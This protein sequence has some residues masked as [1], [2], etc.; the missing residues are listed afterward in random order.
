MG[1]TNGGD[2]DGL[3]VAYLAQIQSEIIRGINERLEF[4][5][6]STINFA[7]NGGS[8][9]YP[10]AAELAGLPI[11]GSAVR[12]N[13][14]LIRSTIRAASWWGWSAGGFATPGFDGY[15]KRTVTG[16]IGGTAKVY[17]LFSSGSYDYWD[18]ILADIGYTATDWLVGDHALDANFW[19]GA[20]KILDRCVVA[21]L[22]PDSDCFTGSNQRYKTNAVAQPTEA[23]AWSGITTATPPYTPF[24]TM[25]Y[26]E[27][28]L[29]NYR[30]TVAALDMD[31]DCETGKWADVTATQIGSLHSTWSDGL[32]A[33]M[34]DSVWDDDIDLGDL[35]VFTS[36][37]GIYNHIVSS[38]TLTLGGTTSLSVSMANDTGD[39]PFTITDSGGWL[40]VFFSTYNVIDVDASY[41]TWIEA[42]LANDLA[43]Q[44]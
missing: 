37:A 18:L 17:R 9:A 24:G 41:G 12:S 33:V 31:I 16:G 25:V 7:Y 32:G 35:G 29:T 26:L 5:A 11:N 27:Q 21:Y 23:G 43:D 3:S 44:A 13:M 20:R 39:E 15:W 6:R 4:T 30:Y 36:A 1:W 42:T 38:S 19:E 8:K 40:R 2:Y 22:V 34:P 28:P 10:S 14:N